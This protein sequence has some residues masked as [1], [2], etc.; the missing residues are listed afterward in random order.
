MVYGTAGG[1]DLVA[2]STG[3]GRLPRLREL[4]EGCSS[5]LIQSLRR[6]SW[7]T[8]PSCGRCSSSA[9]VDEPPF[10]VREGKFIRPGYSEEVDR[11][12]N[13][14]DHG[15][16]ML[17]D[18]E[19]RTK[20]QTGIRN[21]KV[22]YNKVFGYYIE[23]AKSQTGLVPPDWARK[24]TT[25]NAERYI[26]QELKELEHA[27]L[28]AQ[29]KVTALEYQ[30]FCQLK[31]QTCAHVAQI[32]KAAAAVAQV[33][34]LDSF[35]VV[36][37][38]NGYCMPQVDASNSL[39]IV[40]GATRWWKRCPPLSPTTPT[41]TAERTCAPSSPAPTWRASPPTCARWPS[42]S[43]WPRWRSRA[44]P[45]APPWWCGTCFTTPPP[46]SNS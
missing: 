38:V 24:Q 42:S 34:V 43:S 3:L 4:L 31:E 18:L 40:R 14:I 29:D 16:E 37:A 35:A 45:R 22:S 11:L 12:R 28:S 30:L 19:S 7:T 1:R 23:V 44:A 20:E 27:I 10:S 32:Q 2:L 39:T 21:M 17:A 13:V 15:A 8:C 6:R 41:W 25:V 46:G 9:L 36:A 26:C 5:A 33:D